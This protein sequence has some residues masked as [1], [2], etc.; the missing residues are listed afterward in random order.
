MNKHELIAKYAKKFA[1]TGS[2]RPLLEGIHYGAE[3]TVFVS[4]G[5]YA[6]RIKNAH[7][8]ERPMTIHA[9]TGA[10]IEGVYP[11]YTKLFP[12]DWTDEITLERAAIERLAVV[13]RCI[14]DAAKTLEGKK[15]PP[16]ITIEAKNGSAHLLLHNEAKQLEMRAFFGNTKKLEPSKRS[17]NSEYLNTAL[18][19]FADSFADTVTVKLRGPLEPIVL[20][21]WEDIDVLILPYRVEQ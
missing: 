9:K 21:G 1:Y 8:Y 19:L 5:H 4:D 16:L 6:L 18:A 2:T 11:D 17:L 12:A 3:G 20:S 13:A 15:S 7:S 10:P 14:N